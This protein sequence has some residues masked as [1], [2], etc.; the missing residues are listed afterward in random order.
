LARKKTEVDEPAFEEA[1]KELEETVKLI[2]DGNLGLEEALS[3]FEKG[4]M[5]SRICTKKLE[6][7]ENRIDILVYNEKG[8]AVMKPASLEENDGQL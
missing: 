7:A 5:L 1:L 2:E 3:S 6:S 8:E 4:I